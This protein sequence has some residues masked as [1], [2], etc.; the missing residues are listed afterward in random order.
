MA[1]QNLSDCI[2]M[3]CS[4]PNW[5]R[6]LN[7]KPRCISSDIAISWHLFTDASYSPEAGGGLGAVLVDYQG[8][9]VSWFSLMVG[10]D[11]LAFLEDGGNETII[12]ELKTLVVALALQIWVSLVASR[13]LVFFIDNEGAK[14]SLIRGYSE[15]KAI[16]CIC[17]LVARLIDD[18]V[19]FPWFTRVA[20][21]SN[22][23]DPPSRNESRPFL[24]QQLQ[25]D[26]AFVKDRFAFL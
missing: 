9:C 19:I 12:G 23:A 7:S 2:S 3:V 5:H 8:S 1:L 21:P 16:T 22:I 6:L 18:C 26:T 17:D 25:C 13:H 24:S 14:F 10:N 20:S 15:S 4:K 11:D